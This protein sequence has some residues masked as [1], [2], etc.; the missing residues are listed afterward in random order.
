MK[1]FCPLLLGV[2]AIATSATS[3]GAQ[4]RA[5][6]APHPPIPIKFNLKEAGFVTLVIEDAG[7]K[8]VRNL[9]SETP[10]PA[11]ENTAWWD[12]LDD[13]G[14]DPEAASHAVYHIPGK[15]VGAGTDS[16]RGLFRKQKAGRERFLP[17]MFEKTAK[18]VY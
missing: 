10:F 3:C 16:V 14:R 11:G 5:V 13:V 7:G 15:L 2:A 9:V 12:G 8:R 1:S 18:W 4:E 17:T 6:T